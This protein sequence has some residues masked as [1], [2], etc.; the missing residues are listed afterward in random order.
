[1]TRRI[2]RPR[3]RSQ[4]SPQER[5]VRSQAVQ[6]VADQAL[7]RGSLVRMQRTCGKK[8]CRCQAGQKH[9]ALYLAIRSG[10]RRTMIYV[11]PPLEDTV[12]RWVETGQEVDGLLD[13]IS[14]HCLETF[15]AKKK[16]TFAYKRK[17]KPP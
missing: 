12:R 3:A 14:Q 2:P 17:E 9:P 13:A 4:R 5:E 8:N 11:P 6:R 16:E 1:M 7:L 15:L 10:N